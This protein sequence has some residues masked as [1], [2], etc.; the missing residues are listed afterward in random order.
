MKKW[1]LRTAPCSK[2]REITSWLPLSGGFVA[3]KQLSKNEKLFG[4]LRINVFIYLYVH[5]LK[6]CRMSMSSS[7]KRS[8]P[9]ERK[10]K[11]AL[12]VTTRLLEVIQVLLWHL[13]NISPRWCSL[14]YLPNVQIIRSTYA[15]ANSRRCI[16]QDF[17]NT[18][19]HASWTK[20]LFM[21]NK[22]ITLR[23]AAIT[24]W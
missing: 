22:K 7:P 3:L 20:G 13:W 23:V 5:Y 18:P 14:K 8:T 6:V 1:I 21:D 12:A 4:A 2:K 9:C 10:G 11:T 17:A 19:P 24:Y 15:H 16:A